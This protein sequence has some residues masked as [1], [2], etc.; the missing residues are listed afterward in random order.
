MTEAT[1]ILKL[2]HVTIEASGLYDSGI[3]DADLSLKPADLALVRLERE[4][5]RL[6]LAD[7]VSGVAAPIDG[8]VLFEGEAWD[9]MAAQRVE[10]QRAKIGRVFRDG[11]WLSDLDMDENITLGERHHS[12]KPDAEILDEAAQLARLFGLPGLPRGSL[13]RMRRRDLLAAACVRA[14]LGQPILLVLEDP[15][16]GTFSDIMPGLMSAIRCARSRG[17]A[18]LWLTA[19]HGLWHDRGIHPTI[20]CL[21]SGSQLLTV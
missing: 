1:T 11:G 17:A 19:D 9:R 3:W 8:Q 20:R 7:A 15:G 13:A 4:P 10:Q 2:D 18:V 6:P 14:F 21:M 12:N 5:I 16:A